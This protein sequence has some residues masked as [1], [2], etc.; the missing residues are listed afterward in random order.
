MDYDV[1]TFVKTGSVRAPRRR[2]TGEQ[3]VQPAFEALADH[4]GLLLMR[5]PGQPLDPVV[6][7]AV[8]GQEKFG[9]WFA[10]NF[11]GRRGVAVHL[12]PEYKKL[13]NTASQKLEDFYMQSCILGQ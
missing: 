2:G 11:G 1:H 12:E 5:P 4:L 10:L 6:Q 3:G 7:L 9:G 8:H 13:I